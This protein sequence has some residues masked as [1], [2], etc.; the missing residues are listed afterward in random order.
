M[1]GGQNG[2]FLMG[3]GVLWTTL[4]NFFGKKLKNDPPGD[5]VKKNEFFKN[6]DFLIPHLFSDFLIE[7]FGPFYYARG[8]PHLVREFRRFPFIKSLV[9]G[10]FFFGF[11]LLQQKGRQICFT[12][13]INSS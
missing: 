4:A 5:V 9:F 11:P 7:V 12:T 10:Y 6:V 3:L 1:G 8:T 13:I 2:H